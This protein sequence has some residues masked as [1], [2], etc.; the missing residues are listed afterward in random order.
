VSEPTY[1]AGFST[2]DNL[3]AP[4]SNQLL[5]VILPLAPAQPALLHPKSRRRLGAAA[6]AR[7]QEQK[8]VNHGKAE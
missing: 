2:L 4:R 3:D 8:P 7:M 1:D 5:F 6:T